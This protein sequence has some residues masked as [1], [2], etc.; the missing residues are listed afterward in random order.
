M[1]LLK[2]YSLYRWRKTLMMGQFVIIKKFS[3]ERLPA[4]FDMHLMNGYSL[5]KYSDVEYDSVKTR[6][7]FPS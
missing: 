2:L 7:I 1:N 3:H 4:N 5:V 6:Q